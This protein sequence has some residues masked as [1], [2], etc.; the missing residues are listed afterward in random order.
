VRAAL[1]A[2]LAPAVALAE[3]G[4]EA[5][6]TEEYRQNWALEMIHAADAYA[7]GHTG[8]N[9]LIG[10]IDDGNFLTHAEFAGR[11]PVAPT[12]SDALVGEH[13]TMVAGAAAAGRDGKGMHGVAFDARVVPVEARGE[14]WHVSEGI[15]D[16]VDHGASVVNVSIGPPALP[17]FNKFPGSE[18]GFEPNPHHSEQTSQFLFVDSGSGTATMQAE[19]EALRH[20]ARNDVVVVHAAGN[21]YI[22]QPLASAQ[23]NGIGLLPYIRPENHESGVYTLLDAAATDMDVDNPATYVRYPDMRDPRLQQLDYSDLQGN[24]ITVVAV[25]QDKQIAEYSNRCGVAAPWC[26]A[27]PGGADVETDGLPLPGEGQGYTPGVGTSFAAPMVAGAAAVVR[28]AFPYF[29]AKQTVEVLL[30]TTDASGH[31]ADK[32]V[33]GRGLLDL[34]RAARGPAQFGAEG[35]API[36][37]VDTR[38]HD[39]RWSNDI[40][41]TGGLTKRGAGTLAL[42]GSNTYSGPTT[43]AGGVLDVQGSIAASM[44]TVQH[45][46]TLS[47]GGTVGS[48]DVQGTVAPGPAGTTLKVAGDYTQQRGSTYVAEV[49]ADGASTRIE[50]AGKAHIDGAG[51]KV[52]TPAIASGLLGRD[53]TLLQAAGGIE[54]SY[55]APA[56][57]YLFVEAEHGVAPDDATRY[58]YAL[59]RNQ[60]AFG[61]I[62]TT[63]NQRAVGKGIESTGAGSRLYEAVIGATDAADLRRRFNASSGEV[64]ATLLSSLSEQAASTRGTLL[65]RTAS[66][67]A[68]SAGG[69]AAAW[70]Q[71]S[72]MRNT[73]AGDGNASQAV[74]RGTA[75]TFGADKSVSDSTRLGAALSL[76]SSRMN[77]AD[78]GGKARY[79]S[80]TLGLYGGTRMDPWRLSYGATYAWHDVDTRRD[81]GFGDGRAKAKYGARTAQVFGEAAYDVRLGDTTVQPYVGLAYAHTRSGS[82]KESGAAG[83]S[84]KGAGLGLFHSTLGMRASHAWELRNGMA[85]SVD[86]GLGWRHA[87][88]DT[89]PQAR[90]RFDGG[91]AFTVAGAPIARDALLAE[92]GVKLHVN[93]RAQ[94]RLGYSG[95]VSRRASDHNLMLNANWTF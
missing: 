92:A 17:G 34:G 36:F 82:F 26:M 23:P 37:D 31:L 8:K 86:G 74:T 93:D 87:F 30:T 56:L 29:T 60:K 90:M 55:V 57:P 58:R 62:G 54:G 68:A 67:P 45:A 95:Q 49:A 46:G 33:Y 24:L 70:A 20:A 25:G 41:G 84:S 38:G 1:G 71:V 83:L 77:L 6:R 78:G 4:A 2:A 9:V 64:H 50:V 11:T 7:L 43:V 80:S 27:A 53:H 40:G 63:R 18:D 94:L 65:G 42:T 88:G 32:S 10:I 66:M 14:V 22:E 69:G 39:S 48:T 47:G 89:V 91:Q 51:L 13:S 85:L 61:D 52:T 16:A 19:V 79:T 15:R 73:L 59:T 76:G 72:G 5:F 12:G 21:E 35:F 3:G 28:E 75:W 81:M 44:L